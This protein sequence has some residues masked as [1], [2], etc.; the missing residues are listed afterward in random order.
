MAGTGL[1]ETQVTFFTGTFT[2]DGLRPSRA[3]AAA[4][5]S[6]VQTGS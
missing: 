6:Q 2:F 3:M 4:F 1:P 5:F